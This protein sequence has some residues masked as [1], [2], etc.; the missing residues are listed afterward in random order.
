MADEGTRRGHDE[1]ARVFNQLDAWLRERTPLVLGVFHEFYM[2]RYPGAIVAGG[3]HYL[4]ASED[5]SHT[6]SIFPE[7][8]DTV[9]LKQVD[10]RAQVTLGDMNIKRSALIITENVEELM[11]L[12]A[13]MMASRSTGHA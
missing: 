8:I 4:F 2:V 13:M 12:A 3:M 10:G 11:E 5:G 9:S 6:I 1:R 7:A